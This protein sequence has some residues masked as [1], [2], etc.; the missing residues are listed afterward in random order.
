MPIPKGISQSFTSLE[1]KIDD[2]ITKTSKDYLVKV[3]TGDDN[4]EVSVNIKVFESQFKKYWAIFTSFFSSTKNYLTREDG[5]AKLILKLNEEFRRLSDS[6]DPTKQRESLSARIKEVEGDDITTFFK[7]MKDKLKKISKNFTQFGGDI[8]KHENKIKSSL[9]EMKNV[10]LLFKE[11]KELNVDTTKKDILSEAADLS[12]KLQSKQ[13]EINHRPSTSTADRKELTELLEKKKSQL[14]EK[15]VKQFQAQTQPIKNDAKF[16]DLHQLTSNC[17]KSLEKINKMDPCSEELRKNLRGVVE[18]Q[19][20]D[21]L[22]VTGKNLKSPTLENFKEIHNILKELNENKEKMVSPELKGTF[23]KVKESFNQKLETKIGPLDLEKKSKE[24]EISYLSEKVA[25]VLLGLINLRQLR[26][27][28]SLSS[29]SAKINSLIELI[30]KGSGSIDPELKGLIDENKAKL[31]E[32]VGR[33]QNKATEVNKTYATMLEAKRDDYGTDIPKGLRTAWDAAL[34]SCCFSKITTIEIMLE[35]PFISEKDKTSLNDYKSKLESFQKL[36]RERFLSNNQSNQND[37]LN[38]LNQIDRELIENIEN[39]SLFEK[40]RDSSKGGWDVFY[41]S[42]NRELSAQL[43]SNYSIESI[44]LESNR[45]DP[46]DGLKKFV[47]KRMDDLTSKLKQA[48]TKTE[49]IIK[50]VPTHNK[51]AEDYRRTAEDLRDGLKMILSRTKTDPDKLLQDINKSIL[52]IKKQI[53]RLE[54][55]EPGTT[56]AKFIL[57]RLE[58]ILERE[59]YEKNLDEWAIWSTLENTVNRVATESTLHPLQ[60]TRD[61]IASLTTEKRVIEGNL[62]GFQDLKIAA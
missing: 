10:L 46:F 19:L 35:D 29:E 21:I 54:G 12:K 27:E 26:E 41:Q 1:S 55:K 56:N 37:I 2:T 6:I 50:S 40:L 58:L 9:K 48:E 62:K 52:T 18:K 42:L 11:I 53:E 33:F 24:T 15:I 57:E 36:E 28:E 23:Q 20:T 45:S 32:S 5:K 14:E 7:G 49:E 30:E 22:N 61:K 4:K 34:Y 43:G 3:R 25:P 38:K 59:A 39:L 31:S 8:V 44:S 60:E 17:L 16:A 13:L 51:K 47:G